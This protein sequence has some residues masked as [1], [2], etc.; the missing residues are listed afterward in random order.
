MDIAF[1]LVS[2]AA[3]RPHHVLS[4]ALDTGTA[5][6]WGGKR[7]KPSGCNWMHCVCAN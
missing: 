2:A 5:G 6:E 4:G 1:E 7:E 3:W